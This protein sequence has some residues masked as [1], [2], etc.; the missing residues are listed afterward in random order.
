METTV[1]VF[2][3]MNLWPYIPTTE[4][5]YLYDPAGEFQI[6]SISRK[7]SFMQH[8]SLVGGHYPSPEASLTGE[9]LR[10]FEQ[11]LNSF[12]NHKTRTITMWTYG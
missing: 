11:F 1:T 7:G 5:S 3:V 10:W 6:N 9:M 4:E 12:Q 2:N 8:L